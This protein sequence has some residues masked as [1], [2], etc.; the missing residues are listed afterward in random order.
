MVKVT[1][2]LKDHFVAA[3]TC[4]A[5]TSTEAKGPTDVRVLQDAPEVPHLAAVVLLPHLTLTALQF[6]QPSRK[7][8]LRTFP[9]SY[10]ERRMWQFPLQNKA[11]CMLVIKQLP[12]NYNYNA[13]KIRALP[14]A[15]DAIPT[16][17]RDWM[18]GNVSVWR[19]MEFR[20]GRVRNTD[21]KEYNIFK[22]KQ[23]K[24]EKHVW[25]GGVREKKEENGTMI[26]IGHEGAEHCWGEKEGR[27]GGGDGWMNGCQAGV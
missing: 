1:V 6:S 8:R 14:P 12:Y 19:S 16:P 15:R 26:K 3:N 20:H 7:R 10:I 22:W 11:N 25:K 5:H 21:L 23:K 24:M 18:Q 4:W 17:M 9:V 2:L 27:E 13:K